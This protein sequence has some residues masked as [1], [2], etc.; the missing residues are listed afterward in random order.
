[1]IRACCIGWPIQH[2][3]SPIIHRHWL[4]TYGID[5]D[6]TREGIEP[7]RVADFFRDIADLGFAGC[8]VTL[9]HKEAAFR[10]VDEVDAAAVAVGAINTVWFENGRL[11]GMNTDVPGFLAN[12]DDHVPS[13]E[14]E[15]QHAL[16]I[17]AGGAAR[18]VI[19][20][21]LSRGIGI[22]TVANRSLDKAREIARLNPSRICAIGLED[23]GQ[24][25]AAADLLVNTTS[26]GMTGHPP[27]D[28]PID[29]LKPS[30]IVTDV[31]YVPLFT[32][33]LERAAGRGHR[34]V[35]GLG[36]LLHQAV[37][38]FERWFGVTPKVT[39]ELHD[40]V[41]ADIRGVAA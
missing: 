19:H 41:A 32:D 18:G 16:V 21:L 15:T 8:N 34:V 2:V 31:V 35:G 25:L 40:L 11:V 29:R 33:L 22:V 3:R 24:S 26:L 27:L 37:P 17:G 10:L 39:R 7:D 36:M 1:M 6:Y 13:W 20:G 12:L 9:P 5:G 4:K 28:L 38:G 30:A 14:R 23:V